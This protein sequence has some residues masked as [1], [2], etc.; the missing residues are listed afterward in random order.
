LVERNLAKVE[1]ASSRLV[2]RSKYKK[3]ASA[4]TALPFFLQVLAQWQSGYAADCK[5][6]YVGSI[7]ACAS[8]IFSPFPPASRYPSLRPVSRM[9]VMVTPFSFER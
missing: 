3:E 9:I 5:S 6:V 2:S 8:S 7:P 4:N 1:V